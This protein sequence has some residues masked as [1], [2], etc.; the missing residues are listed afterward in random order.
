[1]SSYRFTR[2]ARGA[3]QGRPCGLC[4]LR[5]AGK[6]WATTTSPSTSTSAAC[7]TP[8]CTRRACGRCEPLPACRLR[9]T[10]STA[11]A[12]PL[13]RALRRPSLSG[14]R[15]TTLACVPGTSSCPASARRVEAPLRDPALRMR[16]THLTRSA[17]QVPGH[18]LVGTVTKVGASVTAFK[19]GDKV[20]V[21]CLVGSCHSC[22]QCGKN[23]EQARPPARS[24][25][26]E[27]QRGRGARPRA[28][29]AASHSVTVLLRPGVHLQQQAAGRPPDL[30]RLQQR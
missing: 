25:V 1:M 12:Y 29:P 22:R 26:V 10:R 7:A 18:E 30:R 19:P 27:A 2:C 24:A 11:T 14:G 23:K 15:P 5:A 17:P 8:T 6:R 20:G 9:H 4:S 3:A 16:L 21:G 28:N 13:T